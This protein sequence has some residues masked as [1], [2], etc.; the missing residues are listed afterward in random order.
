MRHLLRFVLGLLN[1]FG[2]T[3]VALELS[4]REVD[5]KKAGKFIGT[6]EQWD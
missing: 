1:D 2:L 3:D 4:T 6:D 5:G